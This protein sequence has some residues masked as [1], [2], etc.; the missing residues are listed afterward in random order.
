MARNYQ[1]DTNKIYKIY[2]I[3]YIL[4]K[5]LVDLSSSKINF[6]LTVPRK[7]QHHLMAFHPH[8]Q[9]AHFQQS[10]GSPSHPHQ[11]V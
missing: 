4:L 6:Q 5:K 7:I 3:M 1:N 8:Y 9:M 11:S 2:M 10:H